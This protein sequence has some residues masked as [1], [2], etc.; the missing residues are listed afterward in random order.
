MKYE[1]H[2][3][4]EEFE[5][6]ERFLNSE[7][8]SE[9]DASFRAAL[10]EDEVL[11]HKVDEVKTL[12][13]GISETILRQSL[14]NFHNDIQTGTV[15]KKI[16]RTISL[17][18]VGLAA[19]SVLIVCLA[20]W[21]VFKGD[22]SEQLYSTYYKPDP[23]LMT[24]MGVSDDYVFE[25]AMVDYKS[26]DYDKAISGWKSLLKN[27]TSS[28]TLNYFLGAAYQSQKKYDSA[29]VYLQRITANPNASFYEDACWYLGLIYLKKENSKEAKELLSTSGHPESRKLLEALN[30]K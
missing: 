6:I 19:A 7:M 5:Q 26:G 28:D 2:I 24:T 8:S 18:R 23:G 1:Y 10:E 27:G 30:S 15:S 16:G 14:N 11:Q 9:E 21:L 25:K 12:S 20:G 3:S 13:L 17:R 4:P 22:K 29:I